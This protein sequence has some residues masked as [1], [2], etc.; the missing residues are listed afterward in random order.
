MHLSTYPLRRGLFAGAGLL[1]GLTLLTSQP[2][3][4][5][6]PPA[7]LAPV[8]TPAGGFAI[9]GDVIGNTPADTG[10]WIVCPPPPAGIGGAVLDKNGVPLNP[11]T[12][13]HVNDP[14]GNMG[15]DLVF[16]GGLKWFD[17]P[18][19]WKWTTGKSSS[20]TD[21]NNALLHVA[22][23]GLGHIWA[24]VSCDRLSVSGDSYI[25]F[26]FLQNTLSRAANGSFVSTGPHGGRTTNDLLLSLAFTGG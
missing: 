1:I 17:D 19:T 15:T 12:T 11:L 16:T 14:Y 26:E 5:A 25:D 20:K 2:A 9:D 23:D 6:P 22:T 4:A 24:V 10:D 8:A 21:L 18:N 13:I 3:A 7:G